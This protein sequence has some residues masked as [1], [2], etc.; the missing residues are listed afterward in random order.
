MIAT[1]GGMSVGGELS[2]LGQASQQ[3]M[4]AETPIFDAL[5]AEVGLDW[6]GSRAEADVQVDDQPEARHA[7]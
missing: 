2:V 4:E 5:A 7:T 3:V 6:P 1:A